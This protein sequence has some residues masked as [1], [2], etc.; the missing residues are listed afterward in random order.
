MIS[1]LLKIKIIKVISYD[2]YDKNF[3][4]KKKH[5]RIILIQN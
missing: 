2:V 4:N 1:I 5:Y 3:K